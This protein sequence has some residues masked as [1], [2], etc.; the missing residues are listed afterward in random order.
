MLIE[1]TI[2]EK[3]PESTTLVVSKWTTVEKAIEFLN[4][5]K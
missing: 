5:I 1:I 2:K 4:T 3:H